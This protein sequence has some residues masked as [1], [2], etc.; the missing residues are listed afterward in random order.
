LRARPEPV[1]V[2]TLLWGVRIGRAGEPWPVAPDGQPMQ[3][4]AQL[5]LADAPFVPPAL[6]RV[7]ALAV[8]VARDGDGLAIPHGQPGDTWVVRA[9]ATLDGLAPAAGPANPVRPRR[10]AWERIDDVPAY[11]DL[12]ELIDVDALDE[13]LDGEEPEDAIGS[14][15]DGLKVGGWPAL[16]QGELGWAPDE[17]VFVL[18][19]D[20][21]T[22]GGGMSLWG[23]GVLYLGRRPGTAADAPDGW[24]AA[25][26]ML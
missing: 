5:N 14:P 21:D 1:A 17:A 10:V 15:A 3:G 8:F 26:Q 2:E 25:V 6:A 7:A 20:S 22:E 24:L 23:D 19:V 4:L 16:L 18:Q 12:I 11:E 13:L 9:Y